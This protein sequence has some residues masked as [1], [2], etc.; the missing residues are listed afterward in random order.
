MLGA[1]DVPRCLK[2]GANVNARAEGGLTPFDYA[3]RN[4]ALK[5]TD[6]YRRLNEARFKQ[7]G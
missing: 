3:K 2:A 5:G 6:I 1:A 7:G 4:P